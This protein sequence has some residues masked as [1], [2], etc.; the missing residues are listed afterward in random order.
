MFTTTQINTLNNPLVFFHYVS[1]VSLSHS[2]LISFVCISTRFARF[3]SCLRDID[4]VLQHWDRSTGQVN[5][6]ET[7]KS[8]NQEPEPPSAP[9]FKKGKKDKEKEKEKEKEKIKEVCIIIFK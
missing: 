4:N 2:Y 1:Q 5:R 7:P 6:P 8:D 9:G 3:E